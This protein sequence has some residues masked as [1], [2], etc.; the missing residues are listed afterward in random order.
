M[1]KENDIFGGW[2][3]VVFVYNRLDLEQTTVVLR[4]HDYKEY[5]VITITASD[6]PNKQY[7]SAYRYWVDENG[8]DIET[9]LGR[10]HQSVVDE[11]VNKFR[12]DKKNE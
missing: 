10:E 6:T 5:I 2:W 1:I 9:P 4:Y 12:K 7:V 11:V 3:F 8:N